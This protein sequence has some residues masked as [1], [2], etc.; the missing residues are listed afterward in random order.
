MT[1]KAEQGEYIFL[2]APDPDEKDPL[3]AAHNA[4]AIERGAEFWNYG[5]VTFGDGITSK[6]S[7]GYLTTEVKNGQITHTWEPFP[8]LDVKDRYIADLQAELVEAKAHIRNLEADTRPRQ[9]VSIKAA[10]E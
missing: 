6:T 1:D 5:A 10:P 9:G 3:L 4:A 8:R 2:F 7:A